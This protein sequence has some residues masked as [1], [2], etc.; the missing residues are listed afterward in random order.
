LG[1]SRSRTVLFEAK[2]DQKVARALLAPSPDI[3]KKSRGGVK[4]A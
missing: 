3:P 1:R 2:R 4:F